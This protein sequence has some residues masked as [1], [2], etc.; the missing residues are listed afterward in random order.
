MNP[1]V[2]TSV[3]TQQTAPTGSVDDEDEDEDEDPKFANK[4]KKYLKQYA[5]SYQ[6]PFKKN[7]LD[8]PLPHIFIPSIFEKYTGKDGPKLHVQDYSNRMDI[9]KANKDYKCRY[10]SSTQDGP[11]VRWFNLLPPNS[12]K[13]WEQLIQQF[14]KHFMGSATAVYYLLL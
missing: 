5:I 9:C 7:I 10:F 1:T 6:E 2:S 14:C 13:S 12:I 11:T 8:A 3:T 4:F